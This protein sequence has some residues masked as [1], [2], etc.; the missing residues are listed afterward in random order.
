MKDICERLRRKYPVTYKP[1]APP[2]ARSSINPDGPEAAAEIERLS[3]ENAR[4]REALTN[5]ADEAA[6]KMHA[7]PWRDDG[8]PSKHDKCPHGNWMYENCESCVAEY[9]S[10]ALKDQS[11]G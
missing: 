6:P 7:Y 11:N 1:Y 9:A 10:A 2:R 4:L 3:A 8:M 5:I